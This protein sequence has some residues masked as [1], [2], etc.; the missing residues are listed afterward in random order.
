[1][2]PLFE[3][4]CV[5]DGVIRHVEWHQ[6]RYENSYLSFYGKKPSGHLLDG[7][8]WP[9]E[10]EEGCYKLKISYNESFKTIEYEKYVLKSIESLKM[11]VHNEIEYDLKFSDRNVL[12]ALYR[13]RAGCDDILIV[14]NGMI[15]DSSYCNVVF[16]DG[17]NWVTPS[18]PLLRGTARERLLRTGLIQEQEIDVRSLS[19]F[20]SLKL[21]NS[22]RPFEQ[23]EEIRTDKIER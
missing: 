17:T 7:V 3:T 9:R 2:Y 22:M 14:R 18:T 21:I 20:D 8:G 11:I 12:N 1:M 6:W 15:T 5:Q 16:F 4:L 10:P 23:V 13:Q 19:R